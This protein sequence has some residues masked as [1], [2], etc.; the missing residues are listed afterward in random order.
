[1]FA[2]IEG[3]GGEVRSV[4]HPREDDRRDR[5]GEI[6]DAHLFAVDERRAQIDR[7]VGRCAYFRRHRTRRRS[8]SRHADRKAFAR[9]DSLLML[10]GGR[11]LP[12]RSKAVLAAAIMGVAVFGIVFAAVSRAAPDTCAAL[13]LLKLNTLRP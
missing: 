11:E 6:V 8:E 10:E 2:R 4:R 13:L 9:A 3:V 5:T 7:Y 1:M 12:R